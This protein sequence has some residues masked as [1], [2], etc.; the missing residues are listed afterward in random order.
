MNM[1]QLVG[2]N[3]CWPADADELT[4]AIENQDC[5]LVVLSNG[6]PDAYALEADIQVTRHVRVMGNPAVLPQMDAGNA[7][8]AFTVGVGGFLELRPATGM[9][10]KAWSSTPRSTRSAVAVWPWSPVLWVPASWA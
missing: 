2:E 9:A 1:K 4:D 5:E 8:R 3:S 6:D 7:I 10:L